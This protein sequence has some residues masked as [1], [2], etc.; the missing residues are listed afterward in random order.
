MSAPLRYVSTRSAAPPTVLSRALAAGLAPDGGLF[1][2]E[3][4]PSLSLSDFDAATTLAETAT[5]LLRPF[6]NGDA[7]ADELDAI[8]REARALAVPAPTI[9]A[10]GPP[11]ALLCCC[12]FEAPLL[13]RRTAATISKH[14]RRCREP[15]QFGSNRSPSRR[16]LRPMPR[17]RSLV[18]QWKLRT[19][20]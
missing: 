11:L 1:V 6:F 15:C 20:S 17:F 14:I 19:A 3:S 7:L 4:M 10:S 5:M 9:G 13:R 18:S 16:Q 2:P 8:C 12:G